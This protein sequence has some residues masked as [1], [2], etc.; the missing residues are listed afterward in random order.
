[1]P[2]KK[3][4]VNSEEMEEIKQSLNFMSEEITKVAKQQT[5]LLGLMEEVRELKKMVLEKD[6]DISL[7]ERRVNELE[8]YT[9]MDDVIVSGLNI[10]HRSYARAAAGSGSRGG[11]D[12]TMGEINSL[13]QQDF[14]PL[15]LAT[16]LGAG[17]GG[18]CIVLEAGDG[19]CIALEAGDGDCITLEAGDSCIALE[20]GDWIALRNGPKGWNDIKCYQKY[21]SI[22]SSSVPL[23]APLLRFPCVCSHLFLS[24]VPRT[25]YGSPAASVMSPAPVLGYGLV[26]FQFSLRL[27]PSR[28]SLSGV[29]NLMPRHSPP[30]CFLTYPAPAPLARPGRPEFLNLRVPDPPCSRAVQ[31]S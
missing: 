7:L 15:S 9:R 29:I 11:E 17:G 3:V 1:M 6:K 14:I 2:P 26:W 22:C 4:P 16:T 21:P 23:A 20:A 8:Q 18:D 31:S 19:D 12:D 10:R 30:F 28:P 5:Q 25:V 13:E 27:A 24:V